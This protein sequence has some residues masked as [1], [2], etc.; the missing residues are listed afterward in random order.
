[1]MPTISPLEPSNNLAVVWSHSW[2]ALTNPELPRSLPCKELH[3]DVMIPGYNWV[4]IWVYAPPGPKGCLGARGTF[5]QVQLT[6]F[7]TH[8]N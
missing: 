7:P 8:I 4:V 6:K 5:L 3:K 1:M 2:V